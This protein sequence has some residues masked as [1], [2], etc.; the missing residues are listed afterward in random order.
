MAFV[1]AQSLLE[2]TA[3]LIFWKFLTF[4]L[5]LFL[6]WKFAWGPITSAMSEREETIDG[7]LRRAEEALAEARQIQADNEKARREADQ[8]AQQILRKARE[9]AEALKSRDV[10]ATRAK[11]QQMQEQA[12]ADIERQ[13]ESLKE[14]LRAEVADLAIAAAEKILGENLNDQ[15]QRRLVQDFIGDMPRRSN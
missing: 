5:L 10:E 12:Q 8:E 11:I 6:L 2:P 9:E 3:G 4:A 1:L 7:S 15:R 13:K 14:E